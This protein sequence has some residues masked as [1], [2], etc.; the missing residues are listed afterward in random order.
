MSC[1]RKWTYLKWKWDIIE[2]EKSE[3]QTL[4]DDWASALNIIIYNFVYIN[5]SYTR[6]SYFVLYWP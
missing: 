4:K 3:Y 6:S 5:Y 1:V 2:Y